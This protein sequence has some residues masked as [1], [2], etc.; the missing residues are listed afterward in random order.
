MLSS[1][2]TTTIKQYFRAGGGEISQFPC[3][4]VRPLHCFDTLT[5]REKKSIWSINN[6]VL[7]NLLLVVIW[8]KLC[9]HFV[10]PA[11][12][13]DTS[14]VSWC[15]KIQVVWQ[16]VTALPW[17]LESTSVVYD[18]VSCLSKFWRLRQVNATKTYQSS[19]QSINQF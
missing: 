9:T 5:L 11:V 18:Y 14:I 4:C 1:A 2:E 19:N 8:P 6:S 15:S 16:S 3:D 17:F 10:D 13:S 7:V 12:T